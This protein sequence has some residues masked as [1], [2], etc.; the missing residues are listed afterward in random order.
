MN[1]R[2]QRLSWLDAQSKGADASPAAENSS[3]G[4]VPD[5]S[6]GGDFI[7]VHSREDSTVTYSTVDDVESDK[8]STTLSSASSSVSTGSLP[9]N[10]KKVFHLDSFK[11]SFPQEQVQNQHPES[12]SEEHFIFDMDM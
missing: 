2:K 5:T 1:A 8:S 9:G 4:A 12:E 11:T 7:K 6:N 10:L 3:S